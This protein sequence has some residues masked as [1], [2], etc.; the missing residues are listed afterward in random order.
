LEIHLG[1]S[2][3][4]ST[5]SVSNGRVK[6]EVSLLQTMI[7]YAPW[8]K[9]RAIGDVFLYNSCHRALHF[10]PRQTACGIFVGLLVTLQ[11]RT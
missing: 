3:D 10:P 8:L 4:G 2:K 5:V 9:L 1:Y 11:G 7:A 6:D